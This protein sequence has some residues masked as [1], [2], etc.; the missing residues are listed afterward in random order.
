VQKHTPYDWAAVTDHAEYLGVMP[1][2]LDPNSPLQDTEIGKL[3]VTDLVHARSEPGRAARF[4][5]R[6]AGKAAALGISYRNPSTAEL[7][8]VL[9]GIERG[10]GLPPHFLLGI[11]LRR[12]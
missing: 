5:P 12:A 11:E 2:L 7:I 6:I 4:L 1:L 8:R 9:P 10:G 3:V